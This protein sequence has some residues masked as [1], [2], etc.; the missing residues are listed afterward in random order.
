MKNN[1]N[2]SEHPW[3][4]KLLFS[5]EDGSRVVVITMANK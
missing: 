2:F 1:P 4:I 5:K 3:L